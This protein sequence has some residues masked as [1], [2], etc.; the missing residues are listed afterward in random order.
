MN[1]DTKNNSDPE[2]VLRQ[3]RTRIL[4]IFLAIVAIASAAGTAVSISDAISHPDQWPAAI[5][6]SFLE[7]IL[8]ILAV[9]R[10]ID[11]RIRAWGVLLVPYIVGVTNLASFGLG[12][13]GRLFLLAVPIGG[14]ILIGANSGIMMSV[15]VGL[16]MLAFTVLSKFG[17]LQ[18]WLITDR[19]SLLLA[20]WFAESTDTLILLVTIM[21]L[22]I[23]FYRLQVNLIKKER[24]TQV[25]LLKTQGQLEQEKANLEQKVQERT[26]E[27]LQRHGELAILN[28]VSEAMGK[29]LDVKALT[30]IVG[31]KLR[32]IFDS[33]S[34]MI[35]LLDRQ[36]NLIHVPYE[37]DKNEGGY[38]DYVDPFPLGTGLSSNVISTG[39]PLMVGTLEEEVANGAY[40]PP[41]IIEKGTG[42]FSQSWLG[43]PTRST[44]TISV[45]CKHFL[46]TWVWQSKMRAFSALNN[47]H[48]SRQKFYVL[49][50]RQ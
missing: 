46:P 8:V 49:S 11:Y 17:L 42:E 13:S 15:L 29:T 5:L 2:M 23:M 44:I 45:S 6:F 18:P 40:F 28:S 16:T 47:R 24:G 10:R 4:N 25:E 36:T 38:I 9:F 33:D 30:R 34:A 1:M 27:L 21:A 32:E 20:D 22:L 3:W 39:Q 31:D 26:G 14:L 41:E 50:R 43:V 19:N 35:M 7:V 37:F 12:S 48:M